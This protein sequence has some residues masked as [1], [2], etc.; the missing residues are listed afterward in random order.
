MIKL[1]YNARQEQNFRDNLRQWLEENLPEGWGET[2]FE[3][4]DP[5]RFGVRG[6][7]EIQRNIIAERVLGLPKG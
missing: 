1:W 6:T 4:V 3:P 7:A 5:K 2:V